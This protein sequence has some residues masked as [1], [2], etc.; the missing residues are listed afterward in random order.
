MEAWQFFI[1][2]L[3]KLLELLLISFQPLEF[4]YL[5]YFSLSDDDLMYRYSWTSPNYAPPG[6]KKNSWALE[7]IRI[8]V[9]LPKSY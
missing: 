9:D 8:L 4:W 3:L 6:T 5:F 7:V 1:C 2:I